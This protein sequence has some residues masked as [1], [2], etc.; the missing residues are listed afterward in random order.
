[1][2]TAIKQLLAATVLLALSACS[3]TYNSY[4]D[5]LKL[6]FNTP[7]DVNLTLQQ[8]RE[9]R[10]DLMY[11][12][13]GERSLAAMALLR[14]EGGQHKWVSADNALL[15]IE[16]GRIVRTVGFSNDLLY[17]TN[18]QSDQIR[19]IRRINPATDWLRLADWQSGEYGYAIRSRF[20]LPT[21]ETLEFFGRSFN[22]IRITENVSYTSP[23]NFF[24][25]DDSWQNMFWYEAN[26]GTLIKS[27]QQLSPFTERL[28]MTYISRIARLMPAESLATLPGGSGE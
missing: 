9:A 7:E 14:L 10:S 26:S 6:A 16:H 20:S 19:D 22:T 5:S 13:H 17:L 1:M 12:R 8:V 23:A 2:N 15:I 21:D 25:P 4:L 24:R 11:V 27:L 28:E 18:I 3:G